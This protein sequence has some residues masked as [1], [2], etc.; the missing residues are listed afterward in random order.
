MCLSVGVSIER[1]MWFVFTYAVKIILLHKGYI[2]TSLYSVKGLSRGHTGHLSIKLTIKMNITWHVHIYMCQIMLVWV[3]KLE[4]LDSYGTPFVAKLFSAIWVMTILK[5]TRFFTES[6]RFFCTTKSVFSL[7]Q[8][9]FFSEPTQLLYR[10]D[11]V[12]FFREPTQLSIL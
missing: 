10:T 7:N 12:F 5:P 3:L 2:N 8:L 4:Q 9:G 1:T 11:S 6:T